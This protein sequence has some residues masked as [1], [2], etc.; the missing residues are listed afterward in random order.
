MH[1]YCYASGHIGFGPDVPTGALPIA[2]GKD[3]ALHDFISAVARHS[4]DGETLLVPGVPEAETDDAKLDALL[5]FTQWIS[6]RTLPEG[7]E[8]IHSKHRRQRGI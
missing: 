6:A 5:R 1:A 3:Q 2:K 7:I 4:Y 8:T